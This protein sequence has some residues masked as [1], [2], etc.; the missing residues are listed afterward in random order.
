[1]LR[2]TYSLHWILEQFLQLLNFITRAWLSRSLMLQYRLKAV[3]ICSIICNR[4]LFEIDAQSNVTS[5]LHI[6]WIQS[7][8][9]SVCS[10][11]ISL[12]FLKGMLKQCYLLQNL[13]SKNCSM[14]SSIKFSFSLPLMSKAE[15]YFKVTA[16]RVFKC[17]CLIHHNF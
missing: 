4:G 8:K 3:I 10:G 15:T 17:L 13:L 11:L 6:L 2:W 1:M 9:H 12:Y 14:F 7:F 16:N 5:V